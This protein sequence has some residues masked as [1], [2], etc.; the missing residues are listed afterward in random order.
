M[1]NPSYRVLGTNT[2]EGVEFYAGES[3]Q[4]AAEAARDS[5]D[6]CEEDVVI[7]GR[8]GYTKRVHPST[9]PQGPADHVNDRT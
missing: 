7:V 9:H 4:E 8:D 6:Y 5:A 2:R 1:S 3:S